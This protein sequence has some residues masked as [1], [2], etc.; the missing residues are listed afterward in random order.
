MGT[1]MPG[2]ENNA[3]VVKLPCGTRCKVERRSGDGD[4]W[5]FTPIKKDGTPDKRWC[6]YTG[7]WTPGSV[8]ERIL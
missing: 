8:I 3:M 7:N 6:G 5:S 4:W 1:N 2:P